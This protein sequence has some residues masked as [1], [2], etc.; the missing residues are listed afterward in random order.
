MVVPLSRLLTKLF[1]LYLTHSWHMTG[2]Y[3]VCKTLQIIHDP[4][5]RHP[6]CRH[7]VMSSRHPARAFASV[8]N[9]EMSDAS[10]AP[11]FFVQ[12]PS[13]P[14][15]SGMPE[16]V[17]C[18][19]TSLM[20]E[21]WWNQVQKYIH[22]ISYP[23]NPFNSIHTFHSLKSTLC[24]LQSNGCSWF[25]PTYTWNSRLHFSW[26]VADPSPS[27]HQ[28]PWSL[29]DE[30]RNDVTDDCRI[31]RP[32]NLHQSHQVQL[33]WRCKGHLAM[34]CSSHENGWVDHSTAQRNACESCTWWSEFAVYT[35]TEKKPELRS[36]QDYT[37]SFLILADMPSSPQ[38][39]GWKMLKDGASVAFVQSQH[40]PWLHGHPTARINCTSRYVVQAKVL[41]KRQRQ[42]TCFP[43]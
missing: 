26:R 41:T 14:R 31:P 9:T 10:S 42:R 36:C 29:V 30:P 8:R 39:Y 37:K 16:S 34:S 13:G 1:L 22:V 18:C 2:I 38:I 40:P 43:C 6:S 32:L 21:I 28:N 27:Q 19:E 5:L 35:S 11:G 23:H 20:D 25:R 24:W 17:P 3:L 7:V 4:H 12:R 15:K 33:K